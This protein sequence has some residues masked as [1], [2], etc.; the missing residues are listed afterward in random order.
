MS[1][2][3]APDA[4]LQPA[5]DPDTLREVYPD[6]AA[7]AARI[8]HLH[9]ELRAAP[10]EIAE[11]LARG[12]LTD[13]LRGIGELDR[14][15][16]EANAAVDRAEIAGTPAQ[17]HLARLRL[18]HV[19]Q[20][21]GEFADSTVLVTELLAAAGQFGPVIEAFTHQQAG[22]NDFAQGHWADAGAHFAR[23]LAIRDALELPD[24]E[25]EQSRVALAAAQGRQRT[26][27]PGETP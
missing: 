27:R 6:A 13:L 19:H 26:Q 2:P 15:L 17:Q 20:Q 11:L 25:R 24:P 14:A 21:R 10:D 5:Y 4:P 22:L 1:D 7:V 3:T 16:N 18:A 9:V 8:D 23:A 12:E